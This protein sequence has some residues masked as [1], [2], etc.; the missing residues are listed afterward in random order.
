MGYADWLFPCLDFLA[1]TDHNVLSHQARLAQIDTKLM[2]F[3]AIE[4]TIHIYCPETPSPLALL[5]A[6]KQGHAFI[7]DSPIRP[8]IHLS[9][10]EAMMGIA[11]FILKMLGYIFR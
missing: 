10:G 3:P 2:L 1:I 11:Y 5:K 6:L 9:S 8:E 7:S 4:L